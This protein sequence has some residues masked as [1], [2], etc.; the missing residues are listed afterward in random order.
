MGKQAG[1]RLSTGEEDYDCLAAMQVLRELLFVN[2]R[3]EMVV[4]N[5][6]DAHIDNLGLQEC[7][8][9]LEEHECLRGLHFLLSRHYKTTQHPEIHY[10]YIEICVKLHAHDDLAR[11]LKE[12]PVCYDVSKVKQYLEDVNLPDQQPLM[13]FLDKHNYIDELEDLLQRQNLQAFAGSID[14]GYQSESDKTIASDQEDSHS[15]EEKYTK[16]IKQAE[17]ERR[18]VVMSHQS[19]DDNADTSRPL[20]EDG[21]FIDFACMVPEK[22]ENAEMLA[23]ENSEM[24]MYNLEVQLHDR[25]HMKPTENEILR[26][27]ERGTTYQEQRQR[28][29]SVVN[30][31]L[32]DE[33]HELL[34]YKKLKER[35]RKSHPTKAN[36]K[37]YGVCHRLGYFPFMRCCYHK[38][39]RVIRS[40]NKYY[41]RELID[42]SEMSESIGLGATLLLFTIKALAYLFLVLSIV[43]LP[44]LA[45]FHEY[46]DTLIE[47]VHTFFKKLTLGNIGQDNQACAYGSPDLQEHI[48]IQCSFGTLVEFHNFGIT[49]EESSTC[50]KDPKNDRFMDYECTDDLNLFQFEKKRTIQ[51]Y[52]EANCIGKRK[53]KV[54]IK[55][56]YT[57]TGKTDLLSISCFD[58]MDIRIKGNQ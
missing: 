49:E 4:A 23:I 51:K 57:P 40:G 7:I 30:K 33:D 35:L 1:T 6:A 52:F 28:I 14:A 32:D 29:R 13:N 26:A 9:L 11:F 2:K 55:E 8:D 25:P 46:N 16:K 10:R 56:Y 37:P 41:Q 36:G 12:D 27:A 38:L 22:L 58:K 18:D 3:N 15:F 20:K 43:S 31:E 19:D 42:V 50:T 45:I 5:V 54:P 24:E 21:S 47:D 44:T 48:L 53:C 39:T 34:S 17:R